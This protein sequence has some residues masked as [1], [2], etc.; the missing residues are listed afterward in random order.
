MESLKRNNDWLDKELK[1][2]SEEL[3]KYRKEKG[4][5]IAE[6]QRQCDDATSAVEAANRTETTLRR[7]I[8]EISQKADD[9]FSRIQQ[10]QEE[11]AERDQAFKV[12]LDAANRLTELTRNSATTERKRQQDLAPSWSLRKMTLQSSLED[13]VLSSRLNMEN[14]KPQRQRLQNLKSIS[15][16]CKLSSQLLERWRNKVSLL[17]KV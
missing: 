16:N 9:S 8:E 5:R 13:L 4:L 11:A 12:E 15:S 3:T 7:R 1:T 14:E 17:I 2:K 6:L 10:M